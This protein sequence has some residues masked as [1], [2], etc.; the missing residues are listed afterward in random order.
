[1]KAFTDADV[2]TLEE[3]PVLT[4]SVRWLAAAGLIVVTPLAVPAEGSEERNRVPKVRNVIFI[5]GDGMAAAHRDAARLF[6]TG[7][8]EQLVMDSFP[9]SGQ[10][11]TSPD[12]PESAITDSAA[13]ASAWATGVATYNG[14]RERARI[15]RDMHDSL[16][17][18]LSLLAL[19][20][21][22]LELAGDLPPRHRDAASQLRASRR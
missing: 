2:Q 22:A 7:L 4:R 15:A 16:G 6:Y 14:A 11:T 3:E 18:E 21:G 10:L 17:H 13:G 1:M 12:D 19:R 5:N 9:V 20:A 8:G